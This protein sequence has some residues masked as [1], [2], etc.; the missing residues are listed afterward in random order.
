MRPLAATADAELVTQIR[1]GHDL[2]GQAT[3]ELYLRHAPMAL[4]LAHRLRGGD[5]SGEDLVSEAFLR[6]WQRIVAGHPIDSFKSYLMQAVRNLHVDRLR[7]D[8]YLIHLET[9]GE[10]E[11]DLAADS[12]ADELDRLEDA[13]EV[14]SAMTKVNPRYRRALWLSAVE[15]MSLPE[16]AEALDASRS[17]TAVV[18][19]RARKALRAAYGDVSTRLAC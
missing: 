10:H 16:V 9:L 2:D 19:F 7:R 8:S 3:E 14:R 18:L 15:G 12:T 4:R 11:L 13:D 5:G 17:T 6:S 1:T